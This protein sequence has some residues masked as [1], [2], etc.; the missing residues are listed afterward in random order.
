MKIKKSYNIALIFT[1]IG[2]VFCWGL[3]YPDLSLSQEKRCLRVYL[4]GNNNKNM[5]R[6]IKYRDDLREKAIDDL[7]KECEKKLDN[8]YYVLIEVLAPLED[9]NVTMK[10]IK[11]LFLDYEKKVY[12]SVTKIRENRIKAALLAGDLYRYIELNISESKSPDAGF[13]EVLSFALKAAIEDLEIGLEPE[14]GYFPDRNNPDHVC[15]KVKGAKD[16]PIAIDIASSSLMLENEEQIVVTLFD[17]YEKTIK[18][19]LEEWHRFDNKILLI[20]KTDRLEKKFN[21]QSEEYILT[22]LGKMRDVYRVNNRE[23]VW[24]L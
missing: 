7:D 22:I 8:L 3:A 24:S 5:A 9:G 20:L 1:M 14:L 19:A 17:D 6:L 16:G 18:Q 4:S 12:D 11:G 21:T 23:T 10:R 2:V 15:V 13:C